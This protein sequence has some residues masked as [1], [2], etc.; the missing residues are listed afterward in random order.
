[1]LNIGHSLSRT[2][3]RHTHACTHAPMLF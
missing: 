2:T 3:H 1:M